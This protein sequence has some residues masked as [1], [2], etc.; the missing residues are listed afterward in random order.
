MLEEC[1]FTAEQYDN[2][3][4]SVVKKVSILYKRKPCEANIGPYNTVILLLFKSS[5]NLQFVMVVYLMIICLGIFM[6]G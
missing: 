5:M 1:G 2:T 3:L 6:Q 4:G